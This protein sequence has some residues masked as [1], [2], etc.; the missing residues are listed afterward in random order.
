MSGL[1]PPRHQIGLTALVIGQNRGGAQIVKAIDQ[2]ERCVVGHPRQGNMLMIFSHI[3]QTF[4]PVAQKVWVSGA[5]LSRCPPVS[6]V[7]K[8]MPLCAIDC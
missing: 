7:I 8:V 3:D 1:N 2:H 5:A 4:D 6:A